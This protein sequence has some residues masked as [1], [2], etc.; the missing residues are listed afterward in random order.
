MTKTAGDQVRRDISE[1]SRHAERQAQSVGGL[2]S[3]VGNCLVVQ[4]LVTDQ[5]DAISD[6][7]MQEDELN[8]LEDGLQLWVIALRNAPSPHAGLLDLFTNL[9][10]VMQRSTGVLLLAIN[11]GNVCANRQF[12]VSLRGYASALHICA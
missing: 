4:C 1:V 12:T 11:K 2:A 6:R 10:A 7:C 3:A 9:A 5:A 8:L